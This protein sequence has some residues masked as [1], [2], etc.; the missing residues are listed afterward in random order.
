MITIIHGD[1][2]KASRDYLT[3]K[4][5]ESQ[6]SLTLDG[7]TLDITQLIQALSGDGLFEDKKDIFIE[8]LLSKKK[9][10]KELD[11]IIDTL[12]THTDQSIY[13]WE[14][15]LLDKKVLGL[16]PKPIEKSFKLPQMLFTFLDSIKPNNSRQLLPLF[17][18]V[19]NTVEPE[20][21]F[22]MIVR[23]MRL[24]LSLKE[25]DSNPIDEVKRLQPWQV[26]KLKNQAALFPGNAIMTPYLVL[27]DI[28]YLI[29]TG[30]ASLPL[31]S[32]IDIWL[33]KL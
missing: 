5:Q 15:K 22:A 19:L 24:L 13:L 17:H 25:I 1:D 29:K 12:N 3:E 7:A 11:A 18:E 16:F 32:A 27:H 23:Q 2:L 21:L 8:Q 20:V 4:K 28:D 10:S 6:S 30:R 31:S 26:Q 9:K 33:L 14:G